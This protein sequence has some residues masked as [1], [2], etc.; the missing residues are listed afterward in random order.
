MGCHQEEKNYDYYMRHPYELRD[1]VKKCEGTRNTKCEMLSRAMEN[2]SEIV[3]K[4]Q[5]NP[6]QFGQLVMDAEFRLMRLKVDVINAKQKI[7]DLSEK[8]ANAEEIKSAEEKLTAAKKAC[9]DQRQE[10]SMYLAVIG[11]SSPN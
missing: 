8:N 6:E 2:M 11:L 9:K 3:V 1:E 7:Q 10:I 5:D 4:Q